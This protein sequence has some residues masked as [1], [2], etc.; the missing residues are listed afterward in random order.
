MGFRAEGLGFRVEGFGF[1]VS[2]LL[3]RD[4]GSRVWGF[5]LLKVFSRGA[6]WVRLMAPSRWLYG[7]S[8]PRIARCSGFN[9]AVKK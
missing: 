5:R 3:F 1:G 2:G 4:P 6:V 8:G 9:S 7:G